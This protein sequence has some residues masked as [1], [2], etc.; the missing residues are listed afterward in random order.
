M[1]LTLGT[2]ALFGEIRFIRV[3]RDSDR[4]AARSPG[5]GIGRQ[6]AQTRAEAR[7]ARVHHSDQ[8][9]QYA[10]PR[11]TQILE[12]YGVK[13]SMSDKGAAWQN[14]YAERWM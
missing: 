8:G 12:L 14:S 7:R 5:R 3:I 6:R 13:I 11:Y 1:A 9:I 10:T 2:H 4:G